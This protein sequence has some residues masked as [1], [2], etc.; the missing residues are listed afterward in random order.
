MLTPLLSET[1]VWRKFLSSHWTFFLWMVVFLP[2][3]CLQAGLPIPS[4]AEKY[5]QMQY[6]VH[7]LGTVFCQNAAHNVVVLNK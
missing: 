1:I 3:C 4:V 6:R 7:T 2:C 5:F